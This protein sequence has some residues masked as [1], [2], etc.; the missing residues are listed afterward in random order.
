LLCNRK[1]TALESHVQLADGCAPWKTISG[2][3]NL[4]LQAQQ[5]QEMDI[6]CKFPGG[7]SICHYGPN[8]ALW[9]VNLMVALNRSLLNRELEVAL[10]QAHNFPFEAASS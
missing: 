7:G 5:F 9:R 10:Y 6:C 2:T 1:Y 3:E 4:V 8:S